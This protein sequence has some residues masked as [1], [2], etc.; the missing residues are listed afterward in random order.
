LTV[1]TR[2]RIVSCVEGSN[3]VPFSVRVLLELELLLMLFG[4]VFELLPKRVQA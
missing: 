4:D 1:S 2:R 3:C